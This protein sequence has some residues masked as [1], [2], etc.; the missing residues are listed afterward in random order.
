MI[1]FTFANQLFSFSIY[2]SIFATCFESTLQM[3]NGGQTKLNAPV[4]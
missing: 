2:L 4:A 1:C 3:E